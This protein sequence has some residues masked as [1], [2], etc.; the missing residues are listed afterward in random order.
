MSKKICSVVFQTHWDREWYLPFETFRARLIRVMERVVDALEK[1]EL[2]SF[3]FDGQV[4]AAED[5]LEACEPELAEKLYRQMQE[6][7]LVL[8][9]WYVM[10]DEFLCSGESLIRNL[11]IGRKLA[12]S[13]GNYQ[14]V[15]Y[16]P[17]TFGHIG[18][19]PQ[20]LTGFDINN[21]VLW[22]GIDADQSELRWKG[23]DGSEIFTLF[24]TEGYYQHPLNTDDFAT[25]IDVYLNKITKRATTDNLLL[26]QGGDHL[27]PANGNMAERIAEF[28]HSRNDIELKQSDLATYLTTLQSEVS[29]DLPVV[30]GELR[31]NDR[32]FVLPDVLSTR[33]YLKQMNQ[34]AEDT[35]TRKVEPLLAMSPVEHYPTRFL[36][37]SWKTLLTQ[38][39]HDSICGC[40][41]DEVH[42]E[43]VTRYEKLAQRSQAMMDMALLSLGCTND[44]MSALNEVNPFADHTQFSIFNPNPKD[45]NGWVTERVFLKGEEAFGLQLVLENDEVIE[46]VITNAEP[47]F[48]FTSPI[49]DF[50]DRIEGIWYNI[51]FQTEIEGLS[52]KAFTLEKL[53]TSE[54]LVTSTIRTIAN[55]IYR[56][57]WHEDATFIVTDL[58]TQQAFDG[59]GRIESSLDC[60]DSYNFAPAMNDRFSIARTVGEVQTR[61]HSNY[62]EMS[63]NIELVQPASLSNDR[64]SASGDNVTSF[65]VLTIKLY[66]DSDFIDIDLKWHN[67]AKD[68][69]LSIHFPTGVTLTETQADSA[70][71]VVSRPVVYQDNQQVLA[72]KEA[73]VSVNPSQSFVAGGDLQITHAGVPEYRVVKGRSDEIALTLLRSVGWLSRRDFSTR[74]NGAGPDLP[75][76]EAQ[77]LGE[78]QYQLRLHLGQESSEVQCQRAEQVRYAPFMVKGHSDKWCKPV[79]LD[80]ASLQVSCVRRIK[81]ELEIRVWNPSAQSQP[82]V[83]SEQYRVVNFIGDEQAYQSNIEPNQILTLR[84]PA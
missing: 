32:A 80:N 19:M 25:N 1:H 47:G 54:P 51:A 68:Q 6:G 65:G 57:D 76:P 36:E 64:R 48:S 62:S 69:R 75:T 52:F 24:L 34:E 43:M 20:L 37:Q 61:N 41:V 73:K 21:I 28:N 71:E 81:G 77:C 11:E 60:G 17:D 27:R 23:A 22:R 12:N 3:L 33:R 44:E 56:V 38:H 18:Q 31:G 67:Q 5:L 40:S 2:E 7:R 82:I 70:F 50:P 39:A 29:N 8:G 9:P 35:L 10:A 84:L 83:I 26:T 16:L 74:G 58:R 79:R 66:Q 15:G 59:L 42:R 53:A 78:H 49:D 55:D 45:F 13:L 72:N 46:P 30:K 14:K 4:V 63:A